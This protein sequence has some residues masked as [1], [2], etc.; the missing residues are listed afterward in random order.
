N[1]T[2]LVKEKVQSC[3]GGACVVCVQGES[4]SAEQTKKI[5]DQFIK[6]HPAA[7]KADICSVDFSGGAESVGKWI[8]EEVKND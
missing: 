7:D 3:L 6:K 5:A 1:M 2:P 8:S 4:V